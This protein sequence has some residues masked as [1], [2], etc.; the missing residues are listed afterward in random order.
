SSL[1]SSQG[2]AAP[3]PALPR[4]SRRRGRS[5]AES[6]VSWSLPPPQ[7]YWTYT[8]L[9]HSNPGEHHGKKR[10]PPSARRRH[11]AAPLGGP[12][13]ERS[14]VFGQAQQAPARR[15]GEAALPL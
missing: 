13:V 4:A 9:T 6:T 2:R 5:Q 1:R 14:L 12:S 8:R 7:W 3:S 11:Q 10:V 15:V